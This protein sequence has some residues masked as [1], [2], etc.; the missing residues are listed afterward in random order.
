MECERNYAVRADK[1]RGKLA[2]FIKKEDA[3]LLEEYDA[4]VAI[5]QEQ[6]SRHHREMYEAVSGLL[7]RRPLPRRT[8]KTYVY[9]MA[10]HAGEVKI[11]V[12]SNPESRL[13]TLSTANA[14]PLHLLHFVVG[15]RSLERAL[16][17]KFKQ[18]HIRNEW[19]SSCSDIE[20]E[21]VKLSGAQG[22]A[23]N[24]T[25]GKTTV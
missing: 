4:L 16:H 19:Y 18:H 11:G 23:S 3:V 10:N 21:F 6:E 12:S 17:N 15:G 25:D 24:G 14:H 2:E 22:V 20:E 13:R 7:R 1:L 9:L 5:F 8:V